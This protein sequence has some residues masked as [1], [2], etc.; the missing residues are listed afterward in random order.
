MSWEHYSELLVWNK[1]MDLTDE[2]YTLIK[3]LP[4]EEGYGIASQMRRAAVSIPSNI[5][6]GHDRNSAKEFKQFLYIAKGSTAELET[7]LLICIRQ[8]YF[9]KDQSK[10]ALLLCD[11]VARMLT[12]F[13][14]SLDS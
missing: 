6:E 3:A 10:K 8:K 14:K 5:A 7:Q 9:S 2:I 13:I 4:K 11:E 12:A 1:A